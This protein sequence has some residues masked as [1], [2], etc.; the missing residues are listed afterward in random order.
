MRSRAA[1]DNRTAP[2]R[3]LSVLTPVTGH[4]SQTGNQSP[5]IRLDPGVSVVGRAQCWRPE[6]RSLYNTIAKLSD[7]RVVAY[8]HRRIYDDLGFHVDRWAHRAA[9]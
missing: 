6:C 3:S 7:G 2:D 8:C 4:G 1:I 5:P 9:A